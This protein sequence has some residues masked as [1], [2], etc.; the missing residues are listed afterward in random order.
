MSGDEISQSSIEPTKQVNSRFRLDYLDGIRGS[1]AIYIILFHIYLDVSATL[2]D[3]EKFSIIWQVTD[4]FFSQ[5]R[6]GVVIFIVLSGYCL[7]LPIANSE[8]RQIRG[9]ILNYFQ[10][11]ALRILPPYYA[12]L[13][14][15]LICNSLIPKN[16]MLATGTHWNYGQPAFDKGAIIPHLFLVHNFNAEDWMFKINPP[17]WSVALEWQIYFLLP[18]VL[19]PVWRY[20]GISAVLVVAFLLSLL[21]S[22]FWYAWYIIL[23]TLGFIGAV[24][25]LDKQS[26]SL[27]WKNRINWD[28]TCIIFATIWV[29]ASF[30]P[31]RLKP[32][33][34]LI[35]TK[36]CPFINNFSQ[37][38]QF[39]FDLIIGIAVICLIISCSRFIVEGKPTFFRGILDL[40]QSRWLVTLGGFSY[41]IYLVHALIEALVQLC[42][43][44]LHI[45]PLVKL[46]I[47]I[48]LTV[49]LSVVGGY[50]FYVFFEKPVIMHL[51]SIK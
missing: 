12:A 23:F 44:D 27:K 21:L 1:T 33:L 48:T 15:S 3:T 13:I 40:L 38:Q 9:G 24:I 20:L 19:L 28:I 43:K 25:G 26:S 2:S 46:A 30:P 36:I 42:L 41:S 17:M 11:R 18:F 14:L 47:S 39:I 32:F 10:R 45:L 31:S 5:G 37:P 51:K 6:Y 7:T 8:N 49:P 35:L 4:L 29:V 16:I 22:K 34:V 50:A